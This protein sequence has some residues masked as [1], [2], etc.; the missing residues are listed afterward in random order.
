MKYSR[1]IIFIVVLLLVGL[2]RIGLSVNAETKPVVMMFEVKGNVKIKS[3]QVLGAIA[4][5]RIG[6]PLNSQY[7][8][9]D[10][11]A[12]Q[13]IGYFADVQVKS[14]KFLNG[15]KLVFTVI[16]NPVFQTVQITG[17]TRLKPDDLKKK[18][19][20]KPG[21]I[22]N[23]VTFS[24]DLDKIKQYCR[25][26]KG[27]FLEHKILSGISAKGVIKVELVEL[28][29]GKIKIVGL[30]KTKETVVRRELLTKEGDIFDSNLVKEDIYRIG[31]LRL[32][33]SFEPKIKASETS[34]A[35]DLTFEAKEVTH[36]SSFEIGASYSESTNQM[37]GLLS[38]SEN[39]LMGLGQSISIDTTITED[40]NN[41]SFNY[42][43]PWLDQKGTSF[44]I[45]VWNSDNEITSTL[46]S[47]GTTGG[48]A[49]DNPYELDLNR[50]GMLFSF[51]RRVGRDT[52][53]RLKFNFEKNTIE[54]F[55]D[56]SDPEQKTGLIDHLDT[57]KH[58]ASFWDNSIGV[59]LVKNKLQYDGR[60]FVKGG[61]Q[62]SGS[63]S[64]SG[65]FLGSEY[66]Y[67]SAM[68]EGKWFHSLYP[69]LVLGT[70]LQGSYITGEFPDYDQL[71]L[72]GIIRLRGY[73]D[74]RFYSDYTEELIGSG[75]F[76]SNT[77]LRYRLPAHKAL[78]LAMFYDAGQI[79]DS[80]SNSLKYD[81]GFGFRYDIAVMGLMLRVDRAW[82]CD[83]DIR[84]VISIGELF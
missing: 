51:G 18:F 69:N 45:S 25:E 4:M 38:F 53:A 34:N 64:A 48:Y 74:N 29:V 36:T 82:N 47:W 2:V 13:A 58:P 26:E 8:Q 63:L 60:Y 44:R 81:Y 46:N 24:K 39:N 27:L 77:E 62:L 20:Q 55:Y 73:K 66:E 43:D 84:N 10:L 7:I 42:Y 72:G 32:F 59:E 15:V 16:E 11:D 22:F 49:A 71:Y 1:T 79:T 19:S 56:K 70:R 52:T 83:G 23:A 33:E 12:I 54:D 78:T 5:T 80:G 9:S 21:E 35:L 57:S 65:S 40:S 61:Y 3:E 41:I 50:T 68:L 14:E 75:Y 6:Q 30:T 37:G 67:Q 28:K 76:L 31:R 17:L